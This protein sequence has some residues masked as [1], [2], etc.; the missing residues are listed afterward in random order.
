MLGF[1]DSR[2]YVAC[3]NDLDADERRAQP[4]LAFLRAHTGKLLIGGM[5]ALAALALMA[6]GAVVA[7]PAHFTRARL[8]AEPAKVHDG[9]SL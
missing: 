9:A 5:G 6:G 7:T 8:R 2:E 1:D 4:R 3:M